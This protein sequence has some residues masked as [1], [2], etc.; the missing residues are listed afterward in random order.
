MRITHVAPWRPAWLSFAEPVDGYPASRV[1]RR[2][3]DET[4][5]DPA[6]IYATDLPT[7]RSLEQREAVRAVM[8]APADATLLIL[9]PTGSGKSLVGVLQALLYGPGV[10]TVV[11]VPTTS[12]AIDQEAQFEA[13]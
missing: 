8:T 12:L 10:M 13:G 3:N 2:V 4:P 1:L 7:Y 6:W 11:V 5:G 9:L